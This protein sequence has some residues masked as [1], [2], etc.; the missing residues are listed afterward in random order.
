MCL[1]VGVSTERL[2]CRADWTEDE[3]SE[4]KMTTFSRWRIVLLSAA[5]A[6]ALVAGPLVGAQA[7]AAQPYPP[8][9]PSL[10]LSATAVNPGSPVS[11]AATGFAARQAVVARL[12]S[13]LFPLGR[14]RADTQGNVQGTVT[15]PR[16]RPG[17]Y[18]F[19]LSAR[20][21]N[22]TACAHLQVLA[23]DSRLVPG[24][25]QNPAR[26][27]KDHGLDPNFQGDATGRS[28]H[29]AGPA[30]AGHVQ[31]LTVGGAT[32]GLAVSGGTLMAVRRR[33]SS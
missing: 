1:A 16:K 11:F 25:G 31:A 19:T 21:P 7:A 9:P 26:A 6:A 22:I 32:M 27:G 29:R 10:T 14:F 30:A 33:R 28:E 8:P 18:A 4:A 5:S 12:D 20:N 24:T 3:E 15:I 2:T 17:W 23:A 13:D